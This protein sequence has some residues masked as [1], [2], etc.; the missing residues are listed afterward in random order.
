MKDNAER[1]KKMIKR[2]IASCLLE[3]PTEEGLDCKASV[4]TLL[5]WKTSGELFNF[6]ISEGIRACAYMHDMPGDYPLPVRM[7]I[8]IRRCTVST[9]RRILRLLCPE[10]Q[11]RTPGQGLS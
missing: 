3:F 4:R 6:W 9:R 2:R 5:R 11:A 10:Q 8:D 7:I 1:E